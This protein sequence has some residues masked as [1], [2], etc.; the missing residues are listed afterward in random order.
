M[1]LLGGKIIKMFCPPWHF[2]SCT[3]ISKNVSAHVGI[4]TRKVKLL[5]IFT[6]VQDL[7]LKKSGIKN[8]CTLVMLTCDHIEVNI[9]ASQRNSHMKI[10]VHHVSNKPLVV[11]VM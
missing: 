2:G 5:T 1:G 7:N 10:K 6:K 4:F 3:F 9:L 11:L 8:Q